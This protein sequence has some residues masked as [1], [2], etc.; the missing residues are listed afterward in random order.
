MSILGMLIMFCEVLADIFPQMTS[1]KA[2]L[3]F[4]LS[5]GAAEHILKSVC[6][7]SVEVREEWAH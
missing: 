1:V 3:L 7:L 5:H 2:G 6:K 4:K